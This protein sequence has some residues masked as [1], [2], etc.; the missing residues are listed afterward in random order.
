MDTTH[1]KAACT[2]EASHCLARPDTGHHHFMVTSSLKQDN[3]TVTSD[4]PPS[5]M[6]WLASSRFMR[7]LN[8]KVLPSWDEDHSMVHKIAQSC[9]HRTT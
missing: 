5:V 7:S 9:I 3:C 6:A 2:K 1:F 4:I 8:G